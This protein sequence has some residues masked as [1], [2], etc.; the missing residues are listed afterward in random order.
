MARSLSTQ[1]KISKAYSP[2]KIAGSKADYRQQVFDMLLDFKL[3]YQATSIVEPFIGGHNM[4]PVY[5]R[6][7]E[8]FA[9]PLRVIPIT[10]NDSNQYISQVWSR[11]K[12]YP[13]EVSNYY[14]EQWSAFFANGKD[15]FYKLRDDFNANHNPLAL[16]TLQRWG[17]GGK[18][19]FDKDGKYVT[20][21][22]NSRVGLKPDRFHKSVM[23]WHEYLSNTNILSLDYTMISH[24]LFDN[25]I[26]FLDPPYARVFNKTYG[27][28]PFNMAEYYEWVVSLKNS[29]VISAVPTHDI[30][31]YGHRAGLKYQ[32]HE[33]THNNDFMNSGKGGFEKKSIHLFLSGRFVE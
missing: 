12:R 4:A 1:I 28:K 32:I 10:I 16:M 17:F 22:T 21:H 14:S 19:Q 18:C 11:I 30:V 6:Y 29:W 13:N 7:R 5:H 8:Y 31:E 9:D 15:Y 24:D 26:V 33:L 23:Q 20:T 25:A 2:F 27:G 3:G